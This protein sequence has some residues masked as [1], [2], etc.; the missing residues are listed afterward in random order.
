VCWFVL[1]FEVRCGPCG[2]AV[3][4]CRSAGGLCEAAV[5]EKSQ[6]IHMYA[7]LVSAGVGMLLMEPP[8]AL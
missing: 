1:L 7:V 2:H 3:P 4:Y 8:E 6:R 5:S